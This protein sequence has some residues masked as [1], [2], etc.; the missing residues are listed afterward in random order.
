[1]GKKQALFLSKMDVL[2]IEVEHRVDLS[3]VRMLYEP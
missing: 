3:K 1:M 2:G